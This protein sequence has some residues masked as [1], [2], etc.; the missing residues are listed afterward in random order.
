MSLNDDEMGN[1]LR[2]AVLVYFKVLVITLFWRASG[3]PGKPCQLI[4]PLR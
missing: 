1:M 2:E 4:W 3:K